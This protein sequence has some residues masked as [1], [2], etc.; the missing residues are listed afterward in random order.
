MCFKKYVNMLGMKSYNTLVE[1][2]HIKFFLF[3]EIF[4]IS[5]SEKTDSAVNPVILPFCTIHSVLLVLIF[6]LSAQKQIKGGQL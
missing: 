6:I 3:F 5:A 1:A 2:V 4:L